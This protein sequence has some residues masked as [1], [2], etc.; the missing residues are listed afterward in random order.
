MDDTFINLDWKMN[1]DNGIIAEI[2]PKSKTGGAMPG[3]GRPVGTPNKMS[4]KKLLESIELVVGKPFDILIAEHYKEAMDTKD[5]KS[6]LAYDKM[7][8]SRL[9]QDQIELVTVNHLD[10]PFTGFTISNL[11]ANHNDD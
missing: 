3:A 6:V 11:V 5:K 2:K 1:E 10:Q 8:M 9:V 7:F 4:A